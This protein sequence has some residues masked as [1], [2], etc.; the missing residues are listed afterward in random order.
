MLDAF[1]PQPDAEAVK[2]LA[3]E[4]LDRRQGHLTPDGL[5][6]L[7]KAILT[8]VRVSDAAEERTISGEFGHDV[9]VRILRPASPAA[10]VLVSLHSS[11][12]CIGAAIQDDELNTALVERLGIATVAVD[13]RLAPEHPYPAAFDDA[14]SATKW[15]GEIG[16]A[17]FGTNRIMLCGHSAG[18]HLASQVII[19][20][21]DKDP[22]LCHRLAAAFLSYGAYDLGETPSMRNMGDDSLVITRDFYDSVM[23]F[24]FPGVDREARRHPSIS[25][26]YADLT[27]L[28]PALFT[29]CTLDPLF[30]DTLFMAARWDAAGNP[31]S[32]DV[33]PGCVHGFVGSDRS[34]LPL[35]IDRVAS[36][37]AARLNG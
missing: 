35:Y 11:G 25:P 22:D 12:W 4:L 3:A 34:T 13:Y 9:P 2:A 36:W 14:L 20:L 24:A 5:A 1:V 15:V 26:L 16:E 31:T 8:G 19:H 7:R 23:E 18:A 30:D 27:G 29:A 6:E 10:A 17:E 21:R 37:L 28:P 32:L 33:W